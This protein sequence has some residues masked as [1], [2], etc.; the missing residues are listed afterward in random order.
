MKLLN[1][2]ALV[3]YAVFVSAAIASAAQDRITKNVEPTQLVQLKG[4]MNPRA[5]AEL[6]QG[7]ADPALR[8]QYATLYLRPAEGLET[9]LADQQSPSSP[10]F[11]KWL[12]PE[13]FGE[14]FGLSGND[15]GKVTGWLQSSGFTIN[16]VARGRCWITFS[17]T[18]A[19]ASRAFHTEIH[20]YSINGE[21]H[22]A[23]STELSIPSALEPAILGLG[24]LTDFHMQPMH[25]KLKPHVPGDNQHFLGPDD[26]ATIYDVTPLYSAGIDGTGQMI[27]ILGESDIDLTDIALY[28]AN[29]NLPPNPPQLVLYGPDPGFVPGAQFEANLDLEISGA[30]ARKAT[31]SEEHTSEL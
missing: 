26:L 15:L 27:A 16:D 4:Q 3:S 24:G 30:I 11:H 2:I 18:A 6:D 25:A 12:T 14:R 28:Q 8:I 9:F 20:R 1:H 13:Q 23:N 19:Q 29:F 22:F 21:S 31:R 7:P 5:R 10:N 17:G